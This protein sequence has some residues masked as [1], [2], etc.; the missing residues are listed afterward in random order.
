MTDEKPPAVPEP[1]GPPPVPG[2]EIFDPVE[3]PA[4]TVPPAAEPAGP[5]LAHP[6]LRA[7]AF[8]LDGAGTVV[9]TTIVVFSGLGATYGLSFYGIL[10]VPIASA[11]LSTVLTAFLGV[12]PSKAILGLKVVDADTG[13][14]I[15]W[16]SIL[17]SLVIVAPIG[18]AFLVTWASYYLPYEYTSG[19]F[20]FFGVF[21][22]PPIAGWIALLVVVT[23]RPRYRGLQDLA[24]RSIV[25]RR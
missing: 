8:F 20:S 2:V 9:V 19:M 16:R 12:T 13:A 17:R 24:G 10:L 14:P 25:V 7:L 11:V 5:V 3:V 22:L 1:D 15:G 6:V 4:S 21:L 23:V 18:L